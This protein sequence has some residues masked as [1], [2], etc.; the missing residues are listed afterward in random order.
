[1]NEKELVRFIFELGHLKKIKRE[2]WRLAG[3]TLPES[4]SEHT[5]RAAQIGFILAKLEGYEN[6]YE[7]C[8]MIVFHELEECRIGDIHRIARKYVV[9]SEEKCVTEQTEKL[10]GIGKDIFKLWKS[11]KDK[12][13]KAG[14]IA[15]DADLLEMAFT[16]KEYLE[17]GYP[18]QHWIDVVSKNLVTDSAKKLFNIMMST[19]TNWWK[20]IL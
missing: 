18:T 14:I 15:K 2:G 19:P 12:N 3:I 7:I 20:K 10:D 6:P 13:N 1:M 16:A 11:V 9:P 4:V 8:T 17:K 5:L